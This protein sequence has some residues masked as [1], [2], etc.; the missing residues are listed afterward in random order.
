MLAEHRSRI[1]EPFWDGA[2]LVMEVVSTDRRLDYEQKRG[3][4][5]KAGIAEYWIVDSKDKKITVL[6]LQ[7]GQYAVHGEF[8]AGEQATSVLLPGFIVDVNAAFA[9]R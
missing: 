3:E 2:D 7:D 9:E 1:G 4:Y 8:M 6:R 5:A